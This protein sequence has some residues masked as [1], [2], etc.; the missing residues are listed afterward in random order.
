MGA[1][2]N[3]QTGSEALTMRPIRPIM[4]PPQPLG[5]LTLM[6]KDTS[7]V[8]VAMSPA[9]RYRIRLLAA[10][11]DMTMMDTV[12]QAIGLLEQ[13]SGTADAN[14]GPGDT[15]DTSAVE[16]SGSSDNKVALDSRLTESSAYLMS[17]SLQKM[18][19]S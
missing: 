7:H 12:A 13:Q 16:R 14:G 1:Y 19:R 9:L 8:K 15:N 5:G 18:A 10:Q 3:S 11:L 6:K 2:T 17:R 4:P